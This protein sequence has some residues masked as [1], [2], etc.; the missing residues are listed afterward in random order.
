MTRHLVAIILAATFAMPA[1]AHM[2]E[3]CLE[4]IV[5]ASRV[6]AKL[7]DA[8]AKCLSPSSGSEK[9]S[10][11]ARSS[12]TDENADTNQYVVDPTALAENPDETQL[13]EE[14][15]VYFLRACHA[16]ILRSQGVKENMITVALPGMQKAATEQFGGLFDLMVTQLKGTDPET[17][18]AA[19]EVNY[20]SCLISA[21]VKKK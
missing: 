13:R 6:E 5:D 4:A 3:A 14:I 17:R 11:V 15:M 7:E 9:S 20:E 8:K 2:D 1:W 12:E 19:Y 16:Q 18:A 10:K 21:G